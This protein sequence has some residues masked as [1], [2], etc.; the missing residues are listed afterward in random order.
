M[1]FPTAWLY[2][3][4]GFAR[5]FELANQEAVAVALILYYCQR[6]LWTDCLFHG[7]YYIP[8]LAHSCGAV[9]ICQI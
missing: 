9:S 4:C 7:V 1:V 8:K 3:S 6:C 5:N 2:E